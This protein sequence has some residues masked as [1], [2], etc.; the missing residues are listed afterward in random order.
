MPPHYD[1]TPTQPIPPIPSD[2]PA[3]W[4]RAQLLDRL[5]NAVLGAV[6]AVLV[7]WLVPFTRPPAPELVRPQQER[8]DQAVKTAAEVRQVLGWEE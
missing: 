3:Q 1:P 7:A 5:V 6:A 4:T 8:I 2:P